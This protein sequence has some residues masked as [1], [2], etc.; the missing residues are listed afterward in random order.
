[1]K[2]RTRKVLKLGVSTQDLERFVRT[3]E[4]LQT[5]TLS[6]TLTALLDVY[7]GRRYDSIL[8]DRSLFEG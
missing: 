1:M 4:E 7:E 6:A 5:R 2:D 8:N 3:H